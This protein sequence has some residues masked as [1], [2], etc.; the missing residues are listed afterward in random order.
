M[1]VAIEMP[2]GPAT[3]RTAAGVAQVVTSATQESRLRHIGVVAGTSP[4]RSI[5]E[6]RWL[7]VW[8]RWSRAARTR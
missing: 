5:Q 4:T 1:A 3:A 8:A 7:A 2:R 6:R